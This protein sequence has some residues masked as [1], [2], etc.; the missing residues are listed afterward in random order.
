MIENFKI[1]SYLRQIIII[2]IIL[3]S[4]VALKY[5]GPIIG[6]IL[7]SMFISL[8]F[9]PLISWLGKKG[10]SYNLSVSI[11]IAGAFALGFCLLGFLYITLSQ[12]VQAVPNFSIESSSFLS[13][14]ANQLAQLIISKVDLSNVA[15]IIEEGVFILFAIIFLLYELPKIKLRLINGLGADNPALIKMFELVST[16]IKYFLIR[17]KVN[18]FAATGFTAIFLLFDINFALLWGV[19]TFF[20]GFIPYIGIMIAAIPPTLVAWSEYGLEGAAAIAI[21][22]IIVNTIAESVLFP[23]MAGKG[24]QISIYVVFISLFIWSW[25]LG[26]TGMFMAVPLTIIIIKYLEQFDETRWLA[27]LMSSGNEEEKN[28]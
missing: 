27:Q 22:F 18:L 13:G 17:V 9:Y 15:G 21:L 26:P 1:P 28:K 2:A 16:F 19:L 24:L 5:I 25:I 20:L 6:P 8:L 7:I 11:T 3:I 10:L 12:M 14:Q 23:R 4:V